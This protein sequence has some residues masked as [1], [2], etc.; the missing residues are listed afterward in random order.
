MGS[1]ECEICAGIPDFAA[2]DMS[3]GERLPEESLKMVD[4]HTSP[5]GFLDAC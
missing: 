5:E 3:G 4:A 2:A 1:S